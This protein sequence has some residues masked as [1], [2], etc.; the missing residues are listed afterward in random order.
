M[1]NA[2]LSGDLF[3]GPTPSLARS[4]RQDLRSAEPILARFQN[5]LEQSGVTKKTIKNHTDNIAFFAEYLVYY[6]TPLKR[7]DAA[8]SGDVYGFLSDWFP[9]KALWAN[10]TNMKAYFASFKKF[11]P[12]ME[13]AGYVSTETVADVLTTLKED[14]SAFLA[15]VAEC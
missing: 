6:D 12:W 15:A 2:C 1:P 11:F 13:T 7:L 4:N 9:R 10:T 14:R 5:W 3:A 8:H